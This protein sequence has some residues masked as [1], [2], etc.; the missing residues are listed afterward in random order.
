MEKNEFR[1]MLLK[2]LAEAQHQNIQVLVDSDLFTDAYDL[3][4]EEEVEQAVI[5]RA[6]QERP[7][8]EDDE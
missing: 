4:D 1:A 2:L 7:E 8:V 3:F 5:D 6:N